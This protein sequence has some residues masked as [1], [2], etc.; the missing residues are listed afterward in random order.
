MAAN[1]APILLVGGGT[2]GHVFPLIAVGEE[3]KSKNIPF[4]FVGSAKSLEQEE[5]QKLGWNFLTIEAGKWRRYFNFVSI[6]ENFLDVFRVLIGFFQAIGIIK[7]NK[8]KVIFSKGGFVALPVVFAGRLLRCRIIIHESD[9][10]MG[11][12]N[13]LA[14]RFAN[15]IFTAFDP[16]VYPYP[17]ARYQQVGI[18]IRRSL[19]SAASLKAPKKSSPLIFIIPGSQGARF[20]NDLVKD[21]LD[22]L[23][24]LGTVVHV[25]GKSDYDRFLTVRD[26]LDEN[27]KNRYKPF[28]FIDRELALYYQMADLVVARG[29]ATTSAEGALFKKT[30]Y[31]IP[32]PTAAGNHQAL[33]AENL[34]RA[35][36]AVTCGQAELSAEKFVKD[37]GQLLDDLEKRL[38]LGNNLHT[39]F[40]SNQ[41]MEIVVQEI[42][43]G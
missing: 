17:D 4:V 25:T 6:F 9:V 16:K 12:T 3:L 1:Q 21:S 10:V 5:V 30:M 29:S 8:V 18:P 41:T 7:R 2:G 35:G 37:L 23:L 43:H 38:T 39:Y 31:L 36:A 40:R 11:L 26:R 14:A 34:V 22:D 27:Q 42:V 28:A 33:N 19:R 13:R 20:V 24:A 32:L 15:K